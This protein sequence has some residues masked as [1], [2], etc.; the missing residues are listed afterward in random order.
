MRWPMMAAGLVSLVVFPVYVRRYFDRPT[1]LFFSVLLAISPMLV[2]YSRTARPYALTLLLSLLAIAVFH[3]YVMAHRASWKAALVFVICALSSVWLHLISLPMIVAPFLCFGLPAM[4]ERNWGRAGRIF[5]LGLLTLAGL[6]VLVLPPILGHPEDLAAKLG[7]HKPDVQT[8]YGV[9]FVWLGS[10]SKFAVTMSL[11]M[12]ALG[13]GRA[14]RDFPLTATLLTGLGL[15]LLA[16]LVSQPAWVNHPLTLARYLLAAIPLFLLSIALGLARVI[17]L[18]NQNRGRPGYLLSL[19]LSI[20]VLSSL[21]YHSP[22]TKILATPNSNS[23]HSVYQFDFRDDKNLIAL[24]QEDFPISAFWQQLAV[25]PRD[26]MK[27]AASP[28]SFETQH[29]DAARWEQI[30]G[31][32]V[33]PGVLS[34]FCVDKRWGEVPENKGF[35]FRNVAYLDDPPDMLKRGFD[36]VVYQKPFKVLTNEGE[37]EFGMDTVNCGVTFRRQFK[38]PVYEDDLLV[39][40]PLSERIRDQFHVER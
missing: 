5:L 16:I 14:W 18:L 4:L 21:V 29:W 27:I 3:H 7:V 28:F 26:S 25:F 6:L 2:I 34:G 36:L 8:F 39:V 9:L 12:A 35:R 30:S 19:I 13:A 20:I 31:Q 11:V 15:T 17:T 10:A 32:R 1:S 23:L 37:K 22:L 40:F 33:M 38:E 24:Y